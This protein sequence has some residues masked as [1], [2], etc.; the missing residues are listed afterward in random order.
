VTTN[1]HR[2]IDGIARGD[3]IGGPTALAEIVAESLIAESGIDIGDITR[4]Y[5]DWWRGDAFDT[6]PTFSWVFQNID[7]GMEPTAAVTAAHSALDGVS[8]GCGPAHRN[9]VI[10]ASPIITTDSVPDAARAEALITHLDPV[11]G[12]AAAVV[13]LLCRSLLEGLNWKEALKFVAEHPKTHDA[14]NSILNRPLD[15][16][17]YAFDAVRAA[18]YFMDSEDALKEASLFAGASN[19]CPVI[20]GAFLGASTSA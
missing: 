16:G 11:A 4:R 10:A 3:A 19:Y 14:M 18:I 2:I 17:G 7:A 15:P 20:V 1:Y 8:A 12:D 9:S 5:L 13:A 6:G